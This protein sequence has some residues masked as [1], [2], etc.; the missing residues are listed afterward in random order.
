MGKSELV[1]IPTAGNVGRSE[2][3]NSDNGDEG[4]GAE[5]SDTQRE[6]QLLKACDSTSERSGRT[7]MDDMIQRASGRGH[8]AAGKVQ[9]IEGKTLQ[10]VRE[11]V[12]G[13]SVAKTR[14]PR[15]GGQG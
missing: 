4:C 7:D 2:I 14:W 12:I 9:V 6:S 15:L 10:L 1:S 3:R 5:G 8:G 11:R 13:R